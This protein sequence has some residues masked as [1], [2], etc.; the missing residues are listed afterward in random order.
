[1][2]VFPL[3]RWSQ[4]NKN[5]LR[6]VDYA[7]G[8]AAIAYGIWQDSWISI[9]IGIFCILAAMVKLA[10]KANLFLPRVVSAKTPP[11]QKSR[12]A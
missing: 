2:A 3:L 5:L 12:D 8:A 4:K 6:A 11:H 7:L 1:M 10:E 9:G